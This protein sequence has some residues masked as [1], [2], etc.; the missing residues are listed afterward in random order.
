MTTAT[1]P[2]I[3]DE[4]DDVST[5]S[6]GAAPLSEL[7][8]RVGTGSGPMA[9]FRRDQ[10]N[11]FVSGSGDALL[12]AEILQVLGTRADDG[13]MTGELPWRTD[14]GSLVHVLRYAAIDETMAAVLRSRIA[15]ALARWLPQ[16]KIKKTG[17]SRVLNTN[18][19]IVA[20]CSIMYDVV[21]SPQS[22]SL[23][24]TNQALDIPV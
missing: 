16:V 11:D 4:D 22:N 1:F 20:V 19:D 2:L 8:A 24:A 14:F 9:P 6:S 17:L 13:S 21:S 15:S 23:L 10:R 5:P 12:S 7:A 3:E 18:G